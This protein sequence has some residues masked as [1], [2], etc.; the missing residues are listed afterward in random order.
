LSSKRLLFV[1]NPIAGNTNK[2]D[3]Q[4]QIELWAERQGVVH[5]IFLTSAEQCF[6]R[7][8]AVLM[9]NVFDAVI[10]AGGD[11]T[12]NVVARVVWELQKPIAIGLIPLGSANGMARELNIPP[13]PEAALDIIAQFNPYTIDAIWVNQQHLCLHIGD[14]GLNAAVVKSFEVEG[15][16][17]MGSY[18]KHLLKEL[19]NPSIV[20]YKITTKEGTTR[21]FKSLMIA[22][23]NASRYGTGAIINP[24]GNL[25]DGR[26]E[27][28]IFQPF[29]FWTF[30]RIVFSFFLGTLSGS[31]YVKYLPCNAVTIEADQ[32]QQLQIDGEVLGKTKVVEATILQQCLTFLVPDQDTSTPNFFTKQFQ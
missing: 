32:P 20:K 30:F 25:D 3:L 26:F 5:H 17:G 29:P 9:H 12:L 21:R 6:E 11:G 14:M 16:R 13:S 19:F 27:L 24:E 2:N 28:C 10:A 31:P 8:K 22:F 1:I 4:Q 23:A 7:L 15:S 18:L